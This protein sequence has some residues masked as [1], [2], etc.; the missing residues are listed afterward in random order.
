VLLILEDEFREV[1]SKEGRIAINLKVLKPNHSNQ[2]DF[3]I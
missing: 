2:R 3:E 1:T